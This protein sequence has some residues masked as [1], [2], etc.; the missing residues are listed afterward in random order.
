MFLEI[1]IE[2][3]NFSIVLEPRRLNARDVIVLWSLSGLL[4]AH[5][6]ERLSH[7]I[8][9][10]LINFL[11]EKLTLLLLRAVHEIELLG[12]VVVLLIRIVED[13]TG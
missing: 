5:V 4:E 12:F 9:Q 2:P 6:V 3:Q 13:M 1:C 7:L 8:D 11:L 10:I